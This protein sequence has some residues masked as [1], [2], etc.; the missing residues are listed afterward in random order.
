[1]IMFSLYVL[2]LIIFCL[3]LALVSSPA[4]FLNSKLYLNGFFLVFYR[5]TALDTKLTTEQY[6][7]EDMQAV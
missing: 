6:L 5:G 1:M 4:F 3:K 7:F 2:C